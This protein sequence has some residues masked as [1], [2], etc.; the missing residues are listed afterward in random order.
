MALRTSFSPKYATMPV[1]C[2]AALAVAVVLSGCGNSSTDAGMAAPTASGPAPHTSASGQAI[3]D[4]VSF[5]QLTLVT[6]SKPTKDKNGLTFLSFQYADNDGKVYECILPQAMSQGQYSLSEWVSTFNAYRLPKVLAQK[7]LKKGENL[8]DFPFISPK[9]Q[10]VQQADQPQP[11]NPAPAGNIPQLPQLP[12]TGAGAPPTGGA[13][14][15]PA[16]TRG[17]GM[18]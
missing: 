18:P 10:P 14:P 17:P 5:D 3:T 6:P 16:P 8:G 13:P 4:K 11:G 12:S 9:P 2:V 1:L 7:K 15:P